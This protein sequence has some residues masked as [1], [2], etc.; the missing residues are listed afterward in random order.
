MANYKVWNLRV[1]A[2]AYYVSSSTGSDTNDGKSP[3]TAKAT[4]AGAYAL[5]AP[6]KGDH[7]LLKRGDTW[8]NSP[9]LPC[10]KGGF[11]LAYP[12]L[13]GAYGSGAEP[14]ILTGDNEAFG[15]EMNGPLSYIAFQ[16]LTIRKGV[17]GGTAGSNGSNGIRFQLG[18]T[19]HTG[20][21]L[22]NVYL[23]G[24]LNN[25]LFLSGSQVA[26]AYGMV[27]LNRCI[28]VN[29]LRTDT[30]TT[31]IYVEFTD[32]YEEDE[33]FFI[34]DKSNDSLTG[35]K[36]YLSHTCYLH[37]SNGPVKVT[38]CFA[39]NARSNFTC[40][41]GGLIYNNTSIRGGQAIE[42]ADVPAIV[43]CYGNVC[44]QTRDRNDPP[45]YGPPPV[46]P[47]PLGYG[48]ILN[49]MLP[50]STVHNNIVAHATDG[51]SAV[52]FQWAHGG[53]N[54]SGVEFHDNIV[55]DWSSPDDSPCMWIDDS[56]PQTGPIAIYDNHFIQI[57][58]KYCLALR[59]GNLLGRYETPHFT[60]TNNQYYRPDGQS[61]MVIDEGGG[62][63]SLTLANW[64]SVEPT[65][66]WGKQVYPNPNCTL[67]SYAKA[68]G[69]PDEE[70]FLNRLKLQRKG[71][72]DSRFTAAGFNDY[73]RE[74]FQ[75]NGLSATMGSEINP[76]N[77]SG[78]RSNL[79]N[80]IQTI[81]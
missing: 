21:F 53:G 51:G 32:D 59:Y 43:N 8:T 27:R 47:Q 69:L 61:H 73:A 63:G 19:G 42:T 52:G 65:A 31:Q 18:G 25:V 77:V 1:G 10:V 14:V 64:G 71:A 57:V 54:S 46:A 56:S 50:G 58:P 9:N 37:E 5:V 6:G 40:R 81:Q 17:I 76:I 75:L 24:F 2:T 7:V 4:L 44:Q 3:S 48:I 36:C 20:F 60:W 23:E 35:G 29:P 33:C 66:V 22:D 12:M 28:L 70:S 80:S 74:S 79:I 68:L 13:F 49:N 30:G 39:Y 55:Y 16:D 78:I 41:T 67:L 38:N 34:N 11:S 72:W 62:L 15:T 26:H 45:S